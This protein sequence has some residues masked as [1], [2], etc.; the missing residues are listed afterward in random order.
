MKKLYILEAKRAW[1]PWYDKA[2]GFIV[3]AKDAKSARR[4]A[5]LEAGDEG[6]EVW[7]NPKKTSCKVL[8][9]VGKQKVILR[10]FNA[11]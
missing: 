1:E 9:V 3:R 6:Y 8:T 7:L 4:I 5:G 10:D 2:S 11:A